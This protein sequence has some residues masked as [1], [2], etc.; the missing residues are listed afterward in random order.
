MHSFLL[1]SEVVSVTQVA[2]VDASGIFH[3]VHPRGKQL[4]LTSAFTPQQIC[5]LTVPA[6]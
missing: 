1:T 4:S 3:P 2:A 5:P 6:S